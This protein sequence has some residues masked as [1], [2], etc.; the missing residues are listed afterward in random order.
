MLPEDTRQIVSSACDGAG[1][2]RECNRRLLTRSCTKSKLKRLC[3]RERHAQS[4]RIQLVMPL[5][6]GTLQTYHDRR[7]PVTQAKMAQRIR[8]T[9]EMHDI[10]GG[11][12]SIHRDTIHPGLSLGYTRVWKIWC[13]VKTRTFALGRKGEGMCYRL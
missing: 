8:I 11:Q 13:L 1:V 5:N 6:H 10:V 3:I 12:D 7:Q 2:V 9:T 4:S